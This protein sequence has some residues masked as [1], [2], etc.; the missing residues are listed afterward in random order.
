MKLGGMRAALYVGRGADMIVAML[1]VLKTGAAYIPLDPTDPP[2]RVARLLDDA[3]PR[4]VLTQ[5]RLLAAMP[6]KN[7]TRVVTD[8]E[9]AA[10]PS[11]AATQPLHPVSHDGDAL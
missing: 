3:A 9:P 5:K 10:D 7:L 1:A 8:A 4:V 11:D 2:E 6:R